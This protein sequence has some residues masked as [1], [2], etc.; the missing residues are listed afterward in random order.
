M[1]NVLLIVFA[2]VMFAVPVAQSADTNEC[3]TQALAYHETA[4]GMLHA[5]SYCPW[6]NEWLAITPMAQM[7]KG[8]RVTESGRQ[9][10]NALGKLVQANPGSHL[11]VRF[12]H[13]S[14][15]SRGYGDRA[16][17]FARYKA[18]TRQVGRLLN[19]TLDDSQMTRYTL[20][21]RFYK[22]NTAASDQPR[23]ELLVKARGPLQWPSE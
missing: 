5:A 1:R 3:R 23:F 21:K 17:G 20:A 11:E 8:G 12:F 13:P 22:R 18:L 9:L 19:E 7:I 15:N 16:E 6:T 14:I 2:L 4:K 10:L